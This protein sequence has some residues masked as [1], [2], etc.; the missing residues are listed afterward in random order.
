[1]SHFK[2]YSALRSNFNNYIILES[3]SDNDNFIIYA[4]K[5]YCQ[6]YGYNR[7]ILRL[8]EKFH[9]YPEE[10]GLTFY[11]KNIQPIDLCKEYKWDKSEFYYYG[12]TESENVF[13]ELWD[14]LIKECQ[15][16]G[17]P[18]HARYLNLIDDKM[19]LLEEYKKL[20]FRFREYWDDLLILSPYQ[21][22]ENEI[23]TLKIDDLSMY[24]ANRKN[25]LSNVQ[26]YKNLYEKL[27]IEIDKYKKTPQ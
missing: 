4:L 5:N 19:N 8:D 11:S 2:F 16:D 24:V 20:S 14:N 21:V 18:F 12:E 22:I 25:D 15:F 7:Y 17:Y 3:E 1:M 6:K 23:K 13:E 27:I 10:V 9:R 26:E